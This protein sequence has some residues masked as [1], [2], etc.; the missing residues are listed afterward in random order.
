MNPDVPQS[1]PRYLS[2][3]TREKIVAGV[4]AGVTSMHGLIAQGRGEAWDYLI[5]EKTNAFAENAIEA[6]AAMLL[7]AAKP[8]ISINGNV[9][10]L[11]P[12]EMIALG[13]ILN[14]PLE[15]NIFHTSQAREARIKSHLMKHGA[16]RIL[17]PSPE[18]E[19]Q[20][21]DHNRRFVHPD[22]M[23]KA[24]VVFVPL[25]DGDRCEALIK[26]GKQV[27]T[28]DLNPLSRTAQQASITIVDNITRAVK[29]L[30]Q[31]LREEKQK[32]RTSLQAILKNYNNSTIL[33]Q[34]KAAIQANLT[35]TNAAKNSIQAPDL[36]QNVTAGR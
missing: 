22:G 1:H 26:N 31:S 25:E 33:Q 6:A 8:V 12:D 36:A 5:G 15:V 23:L 17:L 21:I 27:I 19:I 11:V 32:E 20:F 29:A 14:A 35:D 18:H 9:A 3:I 2:L 16:T 4:E 34:A 28:V 30:T 24:D 10:A 7:L 13:E